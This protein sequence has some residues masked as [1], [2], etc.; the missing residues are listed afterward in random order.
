MP[1]FASAAPHAPNDALSWGQVSRIHLYDQAFAGSNGIKTPFVIDG[2]TSS[3]A[4]YTL[5]VSDRATFQAESKVAGVPTPVSEALS[6]HVVS[7]P[8]YPYLDEATQDRIIAAALAVA[9]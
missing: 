3:W 8:M 6:G 5:Q 2:V 7:L 1:W 9:G 4:Q